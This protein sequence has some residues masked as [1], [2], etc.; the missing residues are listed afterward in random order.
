VEKYIHI[1]GA[2]LDVTDEILKDEITVPEDIAIYLVKISTI[3]K[4]V[5]KDGRTYFVL[6]CSISDQVF[7]FSHF[8]IA[9]L[10]RSG[11]LV[12][13]IATRF[14]WNTGFVFLSSVLV[15]EEMNL[16]TLSYEMTS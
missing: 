7:E 15:S 16:P 14:N 3:P 4:F 10:I 8:D 5:K 6:A 1:T 9:I 11:E 2:F 12:Q 13:K